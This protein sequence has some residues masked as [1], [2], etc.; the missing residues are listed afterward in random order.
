MTVP[1]QM[2]NKY[3]MDALWK[4]A[5]EN[6]K[7]TCLVTASEYSQLFPVLFLT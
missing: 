4:I 1:K 5:L 7:I 6:A 3:E 2:I